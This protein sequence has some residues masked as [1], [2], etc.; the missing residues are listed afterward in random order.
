MMPPPKSNR[1]RTETSSKVKAKPGTAAKRPASSNST[2]NL[3]NFLSKETEKHRRSMSR[4][5]GG[6]IALMRSASTPTIPLLKREASEPLS[7]VSVPKADVS[8]SQERHLSSTGLES[9]RRRAETKEKRDA[10]V[11]AEL[12]DAISTLRRPTREV[13]GKA[14]A[15]AEE[16]RAVTSL[17]QLRSKLRDRVEC[18]HQLISFQNLGNQH[19][20]TDFKASSK[21]L[22]LEPDFTMFW[23]RGMT[24][25]L[26]CYIGLT[27]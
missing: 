22:Q 9:T 10:F 15:E 12:Q 13:V 17:S 18:A 27:R 11:R 3:E 25:N 24:P 1:K 21:Q 26:H 16:R 8:T 23:Q 20:T 2:K 19:N 14:M 5:P 7:L 6:V 4:G